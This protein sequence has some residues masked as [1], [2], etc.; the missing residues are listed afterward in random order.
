MSKIKYLVLTLFLASSFGLSSKAQLVIQDF[1][2]DVQLVQD[3]LLGD[4]VQVMNITSTGHPQAI[5]EFS[6]GAGIPSIPMERGIIISTGRIFD[7]VGPNIDPGTS[8]DNG[9]PGDSDIESIIGMTSNDAAVIEFDFFSPADTVSFNYIFASEEYREYVCDFNDA[10]AFLLTGPNPLGGNYV[11]ENIA[12]VPGTST[13]VAIATV[14]NGDSNSTC[15]EEGANSAYFVDN[16]GGLNVEFDGLTQ[17]FTAV[18]IVEPCQLYHIK[19]VIADA[20]D[21]AYDSAVFLEANSF[22]AAVDTVVT[23]FVSDAPGCVDQEIQFLN[24]G[25]S[26]TGIEYEWD[27]YGPASITT[28]IDENPIVSWS[29]P[30]LYR[31]DFKIIVNCGLD[32]IMTTKYVTVHENPDA[33][34]TFPANICSS[35]TVQFTNTG[36]SGGDY[37]HQWIFTVDA[38]PTVSYAENPLVVFDT[39]GLKPVRHIVSNDHCTSVVEDFVNITQ[40]PIA[41]FAHNGPICLNQTVDFTNTGTNSGVDFNWTFSPDGNPANSTDEN[42]SGVTFSSTGNKTVTLVVTDQISGCQQTYESNIMVSQIPVADFTFIDN[43]CLGTGVDFQ[44]VGSTGDGFSYVWDFGSDANPNSSFAENPVGIQFGNSGT[45]TVT[46]TVSNQSCSSNISQDITVV[47]SPAPE[48]AF[49]ST[50]PKCEG[51]SVDFN[52]DYDPTGLDFNWNFGVNASPISSTD[53]NP[54]GISF[55]ANGAQIISLTVTDQLS[56]CWN[57]LTQTVNIF[58]RPVAAFSFTDSVCIGA[59]VDFQNTGSTG[60]GFAHAWSF[61]AH[62][63]PFASSL[64]NPSGISFDTNGQQI[65]TLT[66]S[67]AHCVATTTDTLFVKNSP[68]PDIDFSSTSPAC[69]GED[70]IFSVTDFDAALDYNWDFGLNA[71]PATS[72]DA[73]PSVVY[74]TDG[75]ATVQLYVNDPVT[76]C[77]NYVERTVNVHSV[78][79]ASFTSTAPVCVGETVS[80]ANTGSTGAGH[81][82]SWDFGSGANPSVSTAENPDAVL[83]SQP[84][85]I[86]ITLTVRT[87]ECQNSA[88][89]NIEIF[90]GPQVDFTT[91]APQ[92]SGQ[93]LQFQN[94]SVA[95]GAA[96]YEWT[97]GGNPSIPN[98]TDE[99]PTVTYD[100]AGHYEISLVVTNT[101]TSCSDSLKSVVTV[102]ESPEAAFS[103]SA[104]ACHNEYVSFVN[105]GSSGEGFTYNWFFGRY[106]QPHSSMDENPDE[107]IFSQGGEQAISLTVSNNHCSS[108]VEELI[109]LHPTPIANAGHDTIICANRSAIVGTPAI[110]G[111]SYLWSPTEYFDDDTLAQPMVT[112]IL[113]FSDFVV[114]VTDLATGC[115]NYDTLTVTMMPPAIALAG[116]DVYICLN[117]SVQIGAGVI[118]GQS[119]LW[120]PD[121]S[122]SDVNSPNPIVKPEESVIYTLSV[123][124]QG[125]DAVTDQVKVTV[126]P[127]P[128]IDAGLDQTIAQ[129]ESTTLNAT[130]GVT[131]AWSPVEFI[132]NAYLAN[133]TVNPDDTITYYVIGTDVNG[134]NAVDSVTISVK[135]ATFYVPN[136]FTPNNDGR[137]D[138]FYI[139]GTPI[140]DFQLQIFNRLSQ[141][142]YISR[143]FYEGWDGTLQN[144]GELCPEGAYVYIVTGLDEQNQRV[145]ISG[146]INL[147]R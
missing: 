82:Y 130:G 101:V 122:I 108:I 111:Y 57:S 104:P 1:L 13:A 10:F 120:S 141:S 49:S 68:A 81:T 61:G 70:I 39:Q 59:A 34:F 25:P 37:S 19:I 67:T 95:G 15:P 51:A 93:V 107:I 114:M 147:I 102:Y 22:A 16:A 92:C 80:F 106:G 30:G 76:G 86:Q 42:P 28:T 54:T 144:G 33:S 21:S 134:C 41:S 38:N 97:F 18:A 40:S 109:V 11:N 129:G 91:N 87:D 110:S 98:S 124:W 26:G 84:G 29:A 66:V 94:L 6:T 116:A 145:K 43:V 78:P 52:Y 139:R 146:Q 3:V 79:V 135:E 142:V 143:N 119:Y 121:V 125:C 47:N 5:G 136:S 14:N 72:T 127:L 73:Q 140:R 55:G 62:A 77:N 88:T 48:V 9:R 53:A 8:T 96:S 64:E 7:A 90:D 50:A 58:E 133:P 117:D 56:G 32:T 36:S 4:G 105:E 31:V 99:N 89:Q 23:D 17:M 137:N 85:N 115:K 132:N 65:I 35:N 45:H 100:D 103:S 69:M 71:N 123:S 63:N 60:S 112:P 128:E 138:V 74:S 2:T 20:F 75:L 113:E 46:L 83:F 24:A 118:E 44:N 126:Y 27:F 12:L 131:Y